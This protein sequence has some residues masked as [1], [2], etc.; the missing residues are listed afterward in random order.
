MVAVVYGW[1]RQ[2]DNAGRVCGERSPLIWVSAV[3]VPDV[4]YAVGGDGRAVDIDLNAV[5]RPQARS[6]EEQLGEDDLVEVFVQAKMILPVRLLLRPLKE[7]FIV[8]DNPTRGFARGSKSRRATPHGMEEIVPSASG[9][10]GW[11]P[12]F[13]QV[14]KG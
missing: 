11:I 4:A 2:V 13:P 14:A 6:A 10:F 5:V 1:R 7:N 3:A 8:S 12:Q 9:D